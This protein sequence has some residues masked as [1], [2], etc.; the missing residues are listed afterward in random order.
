MFSQSPSHIMG[1]S[2]PL[3]CNAKSSRTG[4]LILGFT[5]DNPPL[6]ITMVESHVLIVQLSS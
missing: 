4:G 3:P 2:G 6:D 5:S 1:I